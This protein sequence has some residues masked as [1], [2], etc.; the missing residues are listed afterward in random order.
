MDRTLVTVNRT[1]DYTADRRSSGFLRA[2][3]SKISKIER[4]VVI[5]VVLVFSVCCRAQ[6]QEKWFNEIMQG[7]CRDNY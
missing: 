7:Q 3:E 2:L 4:D 1:N 6:S 5:S